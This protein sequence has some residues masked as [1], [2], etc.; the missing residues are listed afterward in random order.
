MFLLIL[1]FSGCFGDVGFLCVWCVCFWLVWWGVLFCVGVCLC[2]SEWFPFVSGVIVVGCL[3]WIGGFGEFLCWVKLMWCVVS[4]SFWGYLLVCFEFMKV[5]FFVVFFG[6]WGCA[7]GVF[8][9]GLC[10]VLFVMS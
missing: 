10:V 1:G 5:S 4:T 9:V 3:L 8:L 6:M 7:V 2:F